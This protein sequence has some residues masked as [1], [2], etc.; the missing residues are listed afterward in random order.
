[1]QH[2]FEFIAVKKLT[3]EEEIYNKDPE[4]LEKKIPQTIN[5]Y[6]NT[7]SA[8]KAKVTQNIY[9]DLKKI[10]FEIKN[11]EKELDS[12]YLRQLR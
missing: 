3:Q 9:K 8:R 5:R 4:H 7:E 2:L 12:F 6:F 1:M 10:P 11:P